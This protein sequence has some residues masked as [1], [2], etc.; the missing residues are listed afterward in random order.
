LATQK[1]FDWE[2]AKSIVDSCGECY[3]AWRALTVAWKYYLILVVVSNIFLKFS[4]PNLGDMIP[5]DKDCSDGW[6]NHQL[7]SSVAKKN[8]KTN[9]FDLEN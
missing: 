7:V 2:G 8:L 9:K 3:Q 5:N 1:S 4:P 6:F